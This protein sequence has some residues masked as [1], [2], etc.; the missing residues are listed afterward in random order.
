MKL[1]RHWL[2]VAICCLIL[3]SCGSGE[4][5]SS[6][7]S[8]PQNHRFIHPGMLQTR[9][10]M[11]YV[12]SKVLSGEEPW[13]SAFKRLDSQA[14]RSYTA[15]AFTHVSTGAYG[16][17][18]VGGADLSAGAGQALANAY[19]G[20]ILDDPEASS[21]AE[22]I[23]RSWA[24]NLWDL[25]GN[26]AK[27]NV[28]WTAVRMMHAAEIL[29]HT[30]SVWT[31]EDD[32]AFTAMVRRVLLPAIRDFFPEANGNWDAAIIHMML[33]IGVWTEDVDVFNAALERYC[34]GKGNGGL[35]KYIY[36]SGQIQE[37]T[38]D[39]SHVQ[40]GVGELLRASR[41]ALSQGVDLFPLAGNRLALGAEY[42][43]RY[44]SGGEIPVFGVRSDRLNRISDIY[45]PAYQ[46][47]VEYAGLKMPYLEEVVGKTRETAALPLLLSAMAPRSGG[48]KLSGTALEADSRAMLPS[49]AGA[50]Q[51]AGIL[52]SD[53]AGE[54]AIF[55]NPGE[56]IQE[57][58]DR[59]AI[60]GREV[61]LRSGVHQIELP[62]MLRSGTRLSGEGIESVVF[63]RP[64]L[65]GYALVA[66]SPDIHDITLRNFLLEAATD[67]R[68]ASDPNGARWQRL[69]FLSPSRGGIF[70]LGNS[71][72]TLKNIVI[73]N[74]TVQHATKEGLTVRGASGVR[75]SNCD[76]SDNGGTVV[77]G[78]GYHHNIDLTHC[79]GVEVSLCRADDS[80]FGCGITLSECSDVR[81]LSCETARNA[82][83]GI[84]LS[85]CDGVTIENC[86][87]EAND[88]FGILQEKLFSGCSGVTLKD[89]LLQLNARR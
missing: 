83:D 23:L 56:N 8:L 75:I 65:G 69:T 67:T 20:Y 86:M 24:D 64:G 79:S 3:S 61:V 54:N 70:L 36:P 58:L 31:P 51:V 35:L 2:A 40:M 77:P 81:I 55:V 28:G 47:F 32:E 12:K 87:S 45:E 13:A 46:Y 4:S 85:D 34:V 37:T 66:A 9:E 43:C 5:G 68:T 15:K 41:V 16:V 14:N 10:D 72:S 38:R 1:L 21:A 17:D 80:P 59:A 53:P 30:S 33:C 18:D 82:L 76:I 26:N 71:E 27:L 60:E 19:A 89:N 57:A 48:G 78:P 42:C 62:L 7:P 29:K 25:D 52:P 44:L 49:V 6:L 84:R 73:E 22:R 74:V 39:W 88:G 63:M 50:S 11:E